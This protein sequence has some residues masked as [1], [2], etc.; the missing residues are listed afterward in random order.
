MCTLRTELR[1][2]N[3]MTKC[4]R[5]LIMLCLLTVL[6]SGC[7][8]LFGRSVEEEA[9][10]PTP[11]PTPVVP[12][13]PTYVVQR[14]RVVKKIEFTG[15][16]SAVE[17]HSLYFKTSGYVKQVLVKRNDLVQEGDLLAELE[18]DDL[19]KQ[20]AQAKVALSSAQLRLDEAN[21]SL[22]RQSAQAELD[23]AAAQARLA[24]TQSIDSDTIAQAELNLAI[25]QE[26][27][28]RLQT[29]QANYDA[30]LLAARIALTQAQI[31]WTDANTEHQEALDR[32]WESEEVRDAYARA[33]Q[34]AVWN[35]QL[36]QSRYDQ[37]L[38]ALDTYQ[39]DL[40][41]QELAISQV[42]TTL[43]Q[44][45]TVDD[46]P[47]LSIEV[48]R[49]QQQ[50]DWLNEGV[51]PVLV[52]E[53]NQAELTLER[54]QAQ[55][56]EAQIIAPMDGKV[57]S[58]S[59][60]AGRPV[61]AFNPAVI[62]VD[63][64][65][66]EVSANLSTS[67]LENLIED[68]PATVVL[69][70]FPGETWTGAMRR[71]P[72]PFGSG[73]GTQGLAGADDSARISLDG[74]LNALELGDLARVTIVLEE[75]EDALWLPPAAIRTFQGRKFVIVQDADRQRRVDVTV[76]IESRDRVEILD[77]LEEG[78]TIVGQ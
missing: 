59:V 17:E 34:H 23:L 55:V 30:E 41:I 77:G 50:L 78:Q 37:A 3:M 61:D 46:A 5:N 71:L 54:L 57:L 13:Q 39:H 74:D 33:L 28:N 53:V 58:L 63:P 66:K 62:V 14:G 27:L 68:Q 8:S 38:A 43:A 6:L 31:A 75:K 60:Y 35:L 73:G 65:A 64:A 7:Q 22:E 70:A 32:P 21:K 67:D 4:Y 72:Y 10:T 25:A 11:I 16:I 47:L 40:N 69:S 20:L 9:A 76:G 12:D 48:Q 15:R 26:Q 44:L 42:E 56:A 36:T 24:E 19:L 2:K 1:K 29:L 45:Q 18:I 52:N 51:D 49:A